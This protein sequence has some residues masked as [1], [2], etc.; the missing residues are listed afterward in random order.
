MTEGSADLDPPG[1]AADR[2]CERLRQ[3]A[4]WATAPQWLESSIMR[5]LGISRDDDL[6]PLPRWFDR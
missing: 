4:V 3:D 5:E 6:V 1:R 2:L